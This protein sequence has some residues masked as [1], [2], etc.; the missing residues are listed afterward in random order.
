[1]KKIN[2]VIMA[3]V[4]GLMVTLGGITKPAEAFDT[5]LI[6]GYWDVSFVSRELDSMRAGDEG[7]DHWAKWTYKVTALMDTGS[8]PGEFTHLGFGLTDDFFNLG[9]I[10]GSVAIMDASDMDVTSSNIVTFETGGSAP[11][12]G[13]GNR[14]QFNNLGDLVTEGPEEGEDEGDFN[15]FMFST[16][17]AEISDIALG[18][19]R[20]DIREFAT[21]SGPGALTDPDLDTIPVPS[22]VILMGLGLAGLAGAEVRR[23]RKKKAVDN[24]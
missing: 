9:G 7:F 10:L 6:G 2:I 17:F 23:R 13:M 8:A 24:S 5:G 21:I 20:D 18:I 22:T 3:F 14:L 16:P 15:T 19:K 11:L 4:V 1:M 12:E